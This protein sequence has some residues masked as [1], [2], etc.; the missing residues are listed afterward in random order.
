MVY[1]H[2]YVHAHAIHAQVHAIHAYIQAIHV[3]VYLL[4]RRALMT[5]DLPELNSPT[6]TRRNSSSSCL[7][8]S[9]NI[10][11]SAI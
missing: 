7:R 5:D 10:P 9:V 4:P 11:I 3:V 8:A 2:T 1:I 6:T